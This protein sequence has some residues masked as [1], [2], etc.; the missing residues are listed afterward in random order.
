[1]VHSADARFDGMR[2]YMVLCTTAIY[3]VCGQYLFKAG[4]PTSAVYEIRGDYIHKMSRRHRYLE[5]QFEI[6]GST[7]HAARGAGQAIYEIR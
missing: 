4:R 2:V 6:K 1:M 3:E 7:I 5:P